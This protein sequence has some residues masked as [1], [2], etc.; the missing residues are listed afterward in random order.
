MWNC[1]GKYARQKVIL[2]FLSWSRTWCFLHRSVLILCVLCNF[3]LIVW[4]THD[5]YRRIWVLSKLICAWWS[6]MSSWSQSLLFKFCVSHS[7]HFCPT[8][9]YVVRWSFV[10]HEL[11]NSVWSYTCSWSSRE[12]NKLPCRITICSTL[13]LGKSDDCHPHFSH[14][15]F[16]VG[17]LISFHLI[18]QT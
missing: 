9:W 1:V 5:W 2:W 3:F 14:V 4:C 17:L 7:W 12:Y 11:V 13:I 15:F 18:L 8:I 16:Y 10:C 6:R